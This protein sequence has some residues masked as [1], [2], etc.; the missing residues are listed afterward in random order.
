MVR[1]KCGYERNC[2]VALL[3]AKQPCATQRKRSFPAFAAGG[4]ASW[5]FVLVRQECSQ[6]KARSIGR[7]GL[8]RETV[9]AAFKAVKDD[10]VE[11]HEMGPF[12][13][14]KFVKESAATFRNREYN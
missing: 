10:K 9:M 8:Q 11:A 1:T 7:L 12:G 4:S 3:G 5:P 6:A 13:T 14:A 2:I